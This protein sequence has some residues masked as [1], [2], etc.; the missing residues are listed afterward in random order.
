MG[1]E[2]R[3]KDGL[4]CRVSLSFRSFSNL[5]SQQKKMQCKG[6]RIMNNAAVCCYLLITSP[7]KTLH[8]HD[9]I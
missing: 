2:S 1:R 5:G 8:G 9:A 3:V 4:K 7:K 6:H